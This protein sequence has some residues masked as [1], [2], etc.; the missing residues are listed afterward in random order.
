MVLK[1]KPELLVVVY[2]YFIEVF[3]I[4]LNGPLG[5]FDAGTQRADM[6]YLFFYDIRVF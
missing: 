2:F 4:I 5:L 1:L 3:E 6:I